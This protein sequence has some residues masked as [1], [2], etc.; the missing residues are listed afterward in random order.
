MKTTT[1][2]TAK[3]LAPATSAKIASL[4]KALETSSGSLSKA[5]LEF[6]AA[7]KTNDLSKIWDLLIQSGYLPEGTKTSSGGRVKQV[8]HKFYLVLQNCKRFY[9]I[10]ETGKPEPK[11]T[12]KKGAQVARKLTSVA[13]GAAGDGA[14][15][16]GAAGDDA[17]SWFTMHTVNDIK[18]QALKWKAEKPSKLDARAKLT[19]LCEIMGFYLA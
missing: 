13:D 3:G 9:N 16:D 14:A 17:V 6:F 15:G 4:A 18:A 12:T 5:A 2:T 8:K 1:K 7:V 10:G 19:A 11:K